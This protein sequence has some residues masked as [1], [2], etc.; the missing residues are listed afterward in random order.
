MNQIYFDAIYAAYP[1][2]VTINSD[3]IV[4][5][6]TNKVIE[7]DQNVIANKI[8]E[9]EE[10]Y[11]ANQYQRDRQSE[12]PSIPEQLDMQYWDRV[13]GT[14]NWQEAILAVKTKHPKPT[15]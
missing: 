3:S 7:V 10:E 5:D 2:A 6:S 12:Y 9:L 8:I 1:N 11:A 14:N 13:N 15:A 4:F